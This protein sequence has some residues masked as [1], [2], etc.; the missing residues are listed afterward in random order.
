MKNK[1]IVVY[2]V[3]F[4]APAS[5]QVILQ[6]CATPDTN[7]IQHYYNAANGNQLKTAF[8]NIAKSIQT[9][10]ISN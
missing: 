3:A 10:R 8:T 4:E 9:L 6:S 1:G 2:A 7:G 5:A